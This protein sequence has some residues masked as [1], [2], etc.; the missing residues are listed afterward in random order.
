MTTRPTSKYSAEGEGVMEVSG[1]ICP[2]CKM[3]V[4]LGTTHYC[5]GPAPA[6]QFV[7]SSPVTLPTGCICPPGANKECEC[8]DCPR[9]AVAA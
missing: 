6:N 9:K 5:P 8:R 2:S 7:W 3:F 4:A 1:S